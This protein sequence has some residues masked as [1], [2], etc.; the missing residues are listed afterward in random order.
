MGFFM[1]IVLGRIASNM[2][3]ILYTRPIIQL[4]SL[5]SLLTSRGYTKN[6]YILSI[7][8]KLSLTKM[9]L[10]SHDMLFH[11]EVLHKGVKGRK[12]IILCNN[13]FVIIDFIQLKI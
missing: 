6:K 7:R 10:R 9:I 12:K 11:R 5:V 1:Y 2:R 4:N 8:R 3:L 13:N